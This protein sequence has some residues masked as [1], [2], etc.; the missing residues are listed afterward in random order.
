VAPLLDLAV[1]V[2]AVMICVSLG[3]LAWTL[4]VSTT[5]VL[6]RTRENLVNARLEL[7][8]AERK[9]RDA[10]RALAD[11]REAADHRNEGDT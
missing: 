3:L 10:A 11:A 6:R 7:T 2:L 1:V 9:L 8:V 5:R 4:G